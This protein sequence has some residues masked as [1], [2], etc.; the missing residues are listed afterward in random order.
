MLDNNLIDGSNVDK[1]KESKNIDKQIAKP[2]NTKNNDK[3]N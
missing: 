3:E 2:T 1:S